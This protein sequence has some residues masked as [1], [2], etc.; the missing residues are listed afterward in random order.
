[1][2][3]IRPTNLRTFDGALDAVEDVFLDLAAITES[4]F[5]IVLL[6]AT[7]STSRLYFFWKEVTAAFVAEPYSPSTVSLYPTLLSLV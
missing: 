2:S 4:S 1:M 6:P 3:L 7:P 5:V